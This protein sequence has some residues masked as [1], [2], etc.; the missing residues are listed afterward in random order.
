[1]AEMTAVEVVKQ[2]LDEAAGFD[3]GTWA[4][5]ALAAL[6]DA[7]YPVRLVDSSRTQQVDAALE[8]LGDFIEV[9]V[10][11]KWHGHLLDYDDNAGERM[12]ELIRNLT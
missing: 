11:P 6:Y 9:W 1:M 3:T 4:K 5:R 12:R 8:A 2:A 7:G 10:D